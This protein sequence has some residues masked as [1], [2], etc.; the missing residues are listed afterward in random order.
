MF[1]CM[2]LQFDNVTVK[3]GTGAVVL[4]WSYFA[5]EIL[6]IGTQLQWVIFS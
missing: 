5:D 4:L 6:W 1:G 3:E 2:C